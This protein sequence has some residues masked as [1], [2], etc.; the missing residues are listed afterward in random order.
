ML[1]SS[2]VATICVLGALALPIVACQ[3]YFRKVDMKKKYAGKHVVVTGG[4]EGMGFELAKAFHR[5]GAKVTIM[6]RNEGKLA[7]AKSQ[8]GENVQTVS[9]DVVNYA[10][11]QAAMEKAESLQDGAPIQVLIHAAGRSQP[12]Y[13]LEQDP[14]I[15]YDTMMINYMGSVHCAKTVASMMVERATKGEIVFLSSAVASAAFLG[16][17]SYAPTKSALRGLSDVLRN[18]LKGTGISVHIAYP[19]DTD[20]PGFKEE[21]KSKPKETS[22]I[23]PPDIYSAESVVKTLLSGLAHGEYH[24]P[25]PDVIQNLLISSSVNITPRGRWA[26][27]EIILSPVVALAMLAFNVWAD[28]CAAPYGRKLVA[29]VTS[30][31]S[32]H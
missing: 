15:F 3:L 10:K 1:D 8:I 26:P 29:E 2:I 9:V 24:L 12:G 14:S 32:N 13:F 30:S 11:V 28:Y 5:L 21:N 31:M 4:S 18:E 16:Y 25:S 23:S 6:A 17:A 20:T 7:N 22:Q 27:V 19:P